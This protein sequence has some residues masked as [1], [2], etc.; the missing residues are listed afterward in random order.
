MFKK[1]RYYLIIVLQFWY[2]YDRRLVVVSKWRAAMADINQ[3]SNSTEDIIAKT[4]YDKT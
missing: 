1:I 2:S 4:G 3:P